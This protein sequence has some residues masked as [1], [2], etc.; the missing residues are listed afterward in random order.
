MH[1]RQVDNAAHSGKSEARGHGEF[2]NKARHSSMG[3]GLI[4]LIWNYAHLLPYA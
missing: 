2:L 3:Y 4:V 1:P